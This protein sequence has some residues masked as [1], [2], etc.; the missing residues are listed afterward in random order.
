MFIEV[1]LSHQN[2]IDPIYKLN[3]K[4]INKIINTSNKFISRYNYNNYQ[5][6][7]DYIG[8]NNSEIIHY[9]NIAISE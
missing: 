1:K 7:Y 9:Q 3:K 5:L 8:I 2:Y 6:Q 4:K